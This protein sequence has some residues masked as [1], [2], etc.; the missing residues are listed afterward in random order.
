MYNYKAYVEKCQDGDTLTL[1]VHLGFYITL[2]HQTFRLYGV[3]A[4]ESTTKKGKELKRLFKDA[5]TGKTVEIET[6]KY[7]RGMK[8]GK[9]KKGKYGRWL[10]RIK[11][12]EF[13]WLDTW[14]IRHKYGKRYYGGKR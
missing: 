10:A 8:K 4:V 7:V 3:D 14:I 13:G 5:L 11:T 6:K 1:T 2:T 12:D 9:S